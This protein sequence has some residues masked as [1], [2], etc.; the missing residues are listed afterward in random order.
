VHVGRLVFGVE[1]DWTWTN[2][3]GDSTETTN[4][5]G[6]IQT[7]ALSTRVNWL[8]TAA[9]RVGVVTTDRWLNYVK[10]GF[11]LADETHNLRIDQAV[12]GVGST[13]SDLSG[14]RLH[15]GF[16]IGVGT[17]YAFFSNWSVKAEYNYMQFADQTVILTGTQALNI[18][19]AQVGTITNI[20][21]VDIRQQLHLFK[22]GLNYHF[23]SLDV[24]RARY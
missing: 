24:V 13:S 2:I 19:P 21:A 4:V 17:E 1:G 16:L 15:T 23:N 5:G 9:V 7:I 14:G 22:V 8:A 3:K 20:Q 10:V 12:V 18:P 11:A 6:L